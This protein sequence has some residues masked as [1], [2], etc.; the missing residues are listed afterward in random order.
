MKVYISIILVVMVLSICRQV[1]DLYTQNTYRS[2]KDSLLDAIG[3][4][5][6]LLWGVALLARG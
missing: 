4:T 3:N 6:L 1:S 2:L 5:A